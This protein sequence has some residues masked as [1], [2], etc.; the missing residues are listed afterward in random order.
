MSDND[1]AGEPL[2]R[3]ERSEQGPSVRRYHTRWHRIARTVAQR[4]VLRS[5]VR[6]STDTDVVGIDNISGLT[7]PFVVVANHSSHLDTAATIAALPY[8]ATRYLAV[9]AAAD[10]FYSRWWMKA[11]TSLF[12]NTY[13]IQRPG[14]EG[15][16]GKG[17]SS[18][19]VRSGVP[20]LL[21][22]EGTRSRDGVMGHFKPGAAALAMSADAPCVP[23]GLIGARDAMPVGRFW[24]VAGRPRVQVLIGRPMRARPGEKPR[25]FTARIEQRVRT[26]VEMQT[27]YVVGRDTTNHDGDAQ[28]EA[29]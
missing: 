20:V 9:G 5:V 28:E 19:L 10:Y 25:D 3:S 21:Y 17:M 12:F 16:S 14:K 22:P 7:R 4:L 29:S 2:A 6:S 24:P 23:I 15:R 26:M 1:A 27:P 8:R 11:L 13:P 18:S